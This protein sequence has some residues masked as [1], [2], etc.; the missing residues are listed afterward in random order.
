MEQN[1]KVALVTGANKGIG[2]ELARELGRNG[3]EVLVGSRDVRL[4]EQAADRLKSEGL[5]VRALR[6]DLNAP[7]TVDAAAQQIG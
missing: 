7:E 2:F 5:T 6:V 3:L 1:R 4:G